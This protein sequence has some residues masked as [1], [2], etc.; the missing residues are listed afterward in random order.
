MDLTTLLNNIEYT[1]IIN[2]DKYILK[3]KSLLNINNLKSHFDVINYMIDNKIW[4]EQE[5]LYNK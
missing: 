5:S 3:L 2:D 1:Q 4:L